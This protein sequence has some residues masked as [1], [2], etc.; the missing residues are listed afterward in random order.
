MTLSDEAEG[1]L[2]GE[3][4]AGVLARA[5]GRCAVRELVLTSP[6]GEQRVLAPLG[7]D[8]PGVLAEAAPGSLLAA[9]DGCIAVLIEPNSLRWSTSRDDLAQALQ[10]AQIA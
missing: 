5:L 10:T 6:G 8:L 1:V 7:T 4:R 9:G 3:S 2:V